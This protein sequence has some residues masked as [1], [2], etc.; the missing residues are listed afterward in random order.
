MIYLFS[1]DFMSIGHSALLHNPGPGQLRQL[2]H[3]VRQ[4]GQ[5]IDGQRLERSG[6]G[7]LPPVEALE[8][9]MQGGILVGILGYRILGNH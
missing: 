3:L 4:Q 2:V 6:S 7:H 1:I 9:G 5:D 8:D